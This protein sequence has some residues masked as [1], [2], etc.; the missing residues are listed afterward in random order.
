MS[1]DEVKRTDDEGLAVWE[2]NKALVRTVLGTID[3]DGARVAAQFMVADAVF[4]MPGTPG[5]LDRDGFIGFSEAFQRAIPD[6]RHII[7]NQ[8][9]DGDCV[10]TRGR[11]VCTHTGEMQGI[12][13][14]G[15]TIDMGWMMEA[16]VQQ[17]KVAD[18]RVVFDQ[19]GLM[20]QMG[21]LPEPVAA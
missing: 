3:R 15:R 4:R 9:A 11:Y 19:L 6:G 10:W 12:Q 2:A 7:E 8:A 1:T 18:V 20:Q 21:A 17:G 16:R 5:P 14:S 13:P